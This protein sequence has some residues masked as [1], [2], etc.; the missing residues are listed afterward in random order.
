MAT[1][2]ITAPDFNCPDEWPRWMRK[3]ERFRIASGLCEKSEANQVN[4]LIYTMGESADDILSS[5][6]LSDEEKSNYDAVKGKFTA[7]F[8]KGINV[9]YER[10]KF[11]RRT[12]Q[13]G[14]TVDQ[15]VTALHKSAEYCSYGG[16]REE[17]IR[18]RLVVGLQDATVSLKLQMDPELT[19]KKA[20]IVASQSETVKKQQSVV[21]PS[22]QPPNV[23]QVISKTKKLQNANPRIPRP[24]ACTRCVRHHLIVAKNVQHVR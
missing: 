21:R 23:D 9:I 5:M 18:D 10:A 20:I 6:G 22:E 16:L 3:F 2:Q 14:E 19:L 12:Q 13:E 4:T 11:N 15:F 24:H 8:V 1:Y 17:M 7:H